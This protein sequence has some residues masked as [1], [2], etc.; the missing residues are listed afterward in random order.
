MDRFGKI[1]L[2]IMVLFWGMVHILQKSL[3][4]YSNISFLVLELEKQMW[5]LARGLAS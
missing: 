2:K 5:A 1:V 3:G 4:P